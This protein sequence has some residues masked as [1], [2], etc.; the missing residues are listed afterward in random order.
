MFGGTQENHENLTQ[1][2]QCV[3][4]YFEPEPSK[5]KLGAWSTRLWHSLHTYSDLS[6]AEVSS[7]THTCPAILHSGYWSD[8]H[9][10]FKSLT[11]SDP[12]TTGLP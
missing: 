12:D 2:L 9:R 5:Y 4:R 3:E 10:M 1:S 6:V 8:I 7:F 11:S